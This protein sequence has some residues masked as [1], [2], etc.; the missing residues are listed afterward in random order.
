MAIVRPA[1]DSDIPRILELY[2][3]LGVDEGGALYR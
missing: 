1:A 3:Q 2:H